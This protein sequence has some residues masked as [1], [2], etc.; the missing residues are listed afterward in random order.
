MQK[1]MHFYGTYCLARAAGVK[2]EIAY[3]IAYSSQFVDDSIYEKTTI[4]DNKMCIRP[5]ITSHKPVDYKNSLEGDQWNIWIPFHFL[6]GNKPENG[7]FLQRMICRKNSDLAQKMILDSLDEQ[8][9]DFFP[10][11]I[12]IVAH[13]YADTFSHFGFVGFEDKH[14]KIE[15]DS[16]QTDSRHSDSILKYIMSK[17]VDF[18]TRFI[19]NFA[20]IIPVGHGSVGTYPDRPYLKWSFEYEEDSKKKLERRD[21]IVHFMEACECLYYYF[22]EFSKRYP[23]C[24]DPY[25]EKKWE[26]ISHT[27]RFILGIE[28][29]QD[30]RIAMWKKNLFEGKFCDVSALDMDINYEKRL[31]RTN[32]A[33]LESNE[34]QIDIKETN[35]CK[36]IRAA[37][38][39]RDYVL[40][41]L[42]EN[43]GL[44]IT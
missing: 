4:I 2:D 6:P 42:L 29:P 21:N 31:W 11:L 27:I 40:N 1:D 14:N 19:G 25:G 41:E 23:D 17:S 44:M 5:I 7:T 28:A 9:L 32:R 24:Q 20:E 30:Q 3:Q 43:A 8:N 34:K 12:G 18:Q 39:H 36:F 38:K 10:H 37:R 16:I 35:A 13:V 15:W 22:N 26:S 33:E